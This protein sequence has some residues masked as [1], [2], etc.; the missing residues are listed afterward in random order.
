MSP[1]SS[2]VDVTV[3]P[4]QLVHYSG[5]TVNGSITSPTSTQASSNLMH[6]ISPSPIL[7]GPPSVGSMPVTG[8]VSPASCGGVSPANLGFGS[9]S[10]ISPQS[11][12]P[13]SI[14]SM[15]PPSVQS[16]N[17]SSVQP[18]NRSPS[19]V[20]AEVDS[21]TT[22]VEKMEIVEQQPHLKVDAANQKV[23]RSHKFC[24]SLF[25]CF[26]INI[27]PHETINGST[28]QKLLIYNISIR[29]FTLQWQEMLFS[30]KVCLN[31]FLLRCSEIK[32]ISI[33]E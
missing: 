6:P 27:A 32:I 22:G 20:P 13:S 28:R 15:N 31:Y 21:T 1:D 7:F 9:M 26:L 14:Q 10:I 33:L 29:V 19:T 12:N 23:F 30:I 16:M 5:V 3:S 18:V 24:L 25:S 17:P 11:V 2:A 8:I 4:T